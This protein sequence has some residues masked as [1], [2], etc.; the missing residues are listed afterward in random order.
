MLFETDPL[1]LLLADAGRRTALQARIAGHEAGISR[2]VLAPELVAR[3]TGW[4]AGIGRASLPNYVPLRPGA[5]NAHRVNRWDERS[6]VRANYH[7]FSF[8]P[9]NQDPFDIFRLMAPVFQLRNLLTG[10]APDAYLGRQPQDGSIARM[11]FHFYPAGEGCMN[12]HRDP[13]GPHQAAVPL[14][15]MSR[16]G[17]D[18]RAGGLVLQGAQGQRQPVDAQL[19]PGDV[20]WFHPQQPHGIETIDPEAPP[21]WLAF[22]GR[23][24]GVFAV[25]KLQGEA[26]IADAADLGAAG[27]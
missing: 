19:Q 18:Y 21:D 14:L 5:P 23:W 8:Q 22:R 24:S 10:A 6:F 11:L 20:I 7:Q 27:A 26:A 15:V 4:L 25:N 1:P 3:L 12:L 2:G 9:W 16:F 13:V 17:Q